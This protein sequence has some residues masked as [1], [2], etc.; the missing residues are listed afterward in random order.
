MEILEV[1]EEG[2]LVTEPPAEE[3][4][5]GEAF[6]K[7]TTAKSTMPFEITLEDVPSGKVGSPVILSLKV[8]SADIV[9]AEVTYYM[10]TAPATMISTKVTIAD[11]SAPSGNDYKNSAI[12]FSYTVS[13]FFNPK[14][15][16]SKILA[17]TVPTAGLSQEEATVPIL[18]DIAE[19]DVI[20]HS[21]IQC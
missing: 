17:L 20:Y 11:T 10:E 9:V 8:S 2:R 7:T 12:N 19:V 21:I 4:A 15:F 14:A 18:L 1:P 13:S 16:L 6:V 3:P 5:T